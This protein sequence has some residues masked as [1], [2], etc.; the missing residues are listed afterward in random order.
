[1][2]WQQDVAPSSDKYSYLYSYVQGDSLI[3]LPEH[4]PGGPSVLSR[5]AVYDTFT[6]KREFQVKTDPRFNRLWGL[7][8]SPDGKRMV[9]D[10]FG[11]LRSFDLPPKQE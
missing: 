3:A 11:I 6:G 4:D 5:I 1:V 10:V 8:I 2:I 9:I 7:A